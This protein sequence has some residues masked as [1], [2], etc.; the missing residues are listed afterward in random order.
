MTKLLFW[1]RVIW[2]AMLL[3]VASD[4]ILRWFGL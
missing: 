2:F 3:I 4:V 1:L